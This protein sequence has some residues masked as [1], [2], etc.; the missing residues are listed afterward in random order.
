MS[1]SLVD[2][3]LSMCCEKTECTELLDPVLK[4]IPPTLLFLHSLSVFTIH[5]ILL[6]FMKTYSL[7]GWVLWSGMHLSITSVELLGGGSK[8]NELGK[9][10]ISLI[11]ESLVERKLREVLWTF[12]WVDSTEILQ[13][14]CYS[15]IPKPILL[16]LFSEN[17][18][19]H[20]TEVSIAHVQ[21]VSITMKI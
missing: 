17:T 12:S 11:P 1:Y 4:T 10:T 14:I 20:A 13:C 7:Q 15:T 6:S 9:I 2:Q 3:H 16:E 8:R 5:I 19:V 18:T 21:T